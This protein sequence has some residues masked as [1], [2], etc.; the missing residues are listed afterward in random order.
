MNLWDNIKLLLGDK[1]IMD[2]TIIH[3]K[4]ND[5]YGISFNATRFGIIV[6]DD[7]GRVW[8][9]YNKSS[10]IP[11]LINHASED[12]KT[13]YIKQNE[14]FICLE[15]DGGEFYHKALGMQLKILVREGA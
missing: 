2:I 12:L 15:D 13:I 4:G 10:S 14:G 9:F 6:V 11:A 7:M 3:T 8:E 5:R 1:E